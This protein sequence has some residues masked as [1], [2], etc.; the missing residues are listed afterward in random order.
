[1]IFKKFKVVHN[2][3]RV[4]RFFEKIGLS[5]VYLVVP[6]LLLVVAAILEGI[7][8]ALLIPTIKGI[9][10]MNFAF[11]RE[12]PFFG[13]LIEKLPLTMSQRNSTVFLI[14]AGLIFGTAILKNVFRYV[15]MIGISTQVQNFEHGIRSMI[16]SRYLKFGKLFFDQHNVGQLQQTLLRYPS[17]IAMQLNHMHDT[18]YWVFTLFTYLAIMFFISW[19]MTLLILTVI[20]VY[21]YLFR[22][23]V[24]MIRDSSVSQTQSIDQLGNRA[25]GC[26]TCMPLIKAYSN[27][28]VEQKSFDAISRSVAA[29]QISIEKKSRLITPT[30]EV[31]MLLITLLL[32]SSVA[33]LFVRKNAGEISGY[34]VLFLLIRRSA[35]GFGAFSNL[36]A[37]LASVKGRIAEVSK[38][39]NDRDKHFVPDGSRQF[40]GL[41]SSIEIRDLNFSYRSDIAAIHNCSF[42]IEKMKKTAIVGKS[43]SGKSTLVSLI[44]RFYDCPPG[45]IF[46]NG[47]DIRDF[48]LRSLRQKMALVS[49]DTLLFNTSL[50]ENLCYGFDYKVTKRAIDGAI[51]RARLEALVKNLPMGLK[52][53]VGDRGVQ[54]S[55]GE[56]QRV[57]IARAIL[58]G[59]E[60]LLLDEATSALDTETEQLIQKALDDLTFGK[61]TIIIAHRLSTIKNADKICVMENGRVME[62]GTLPQLLEK[63]GRFSVLWNEQKF[64]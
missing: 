63:R 50:E 37:A 20:P 18:L 30:Q 38:V 24:H 47:S 34:F 53:K 60:I 23:I 6:T 8:L 48:T 19:Q 22:P 16:F 26:L 13:D 11:V 28:A 45:S 36:Q 21:H 58:K 52:T 42:V 39:F 1:M 51:R 41:K 62:E 5:P 4:K 27:E 2:S 17:E 43:G 12:A 59:A 57:S 15:S 44:M 9:I 7:S 55:G 56:R 3:L 40:D 32:V 61:T 10:E 54:L 64:V 31:I 29:K 46:I 35:S 14:L 33:F 25:A 49:Q